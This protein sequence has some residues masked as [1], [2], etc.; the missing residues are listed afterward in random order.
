MPAE[1]EDLPGAEV[2]RGQ[3]V[4]R[5]AAAGLGVDGD[6]ALVEAAD[7]HGARDVAAR[8]QP[9]I[10]A[11]LDA[12][13]QEVGPGHLEDVIAPASGLPTRVDQRGVRVGHVQHIGVRA[14]PGVAGEE[15]PVV[16]EALLRR[17]LQSLVALRDPVVVSLLRDRRLTW[18]VLVVDRDR[19]VVRRSR[20]PVTTGLRHGDR[21]VGAEGD[22]EL[23]VGDRVVC[24]AMNECSAQ[25]QV[26]NELVI[27]AER[28]LVAVRPPEIGVTRQLK[29]LE[30]RGNGPADQPALLAVLK[31]EVP[32]EV[33]PGVAFLDRAVRIEAARRPGPDDL[34]VAGGRR[35]DG[36]CGP[37]PVTSNTAFTRG[38][39]FFQLG[40]SRTS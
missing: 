16:A 23:D 25:P 28:P 31:H 26:R 22:I 36:R 21:R 17:D 30:G 5:H 19:I 4:E 38:P 2:E 18:I 3:L 15:R 1:P 24:L 7:V 12:V 6:G 29:R 32:V 14:A 39:T 11:D 35:F 27:D 40:M 37:R 34:V 9:E 8:L 13:R 33:V 20:L 10:A